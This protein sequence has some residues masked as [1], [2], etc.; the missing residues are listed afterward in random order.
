MC[1]RVPVLVPLLF[2]ILSSAHAQT[3]LPP[4]AAPGI[5]SEPFVLTATVVDKKGRPVDGLKASDFIIT[6]GKVAQPIVSFD[7]VD[8]PVSVGIVFDASDSMLRWTT[9]RKRNT[10]MGALDRFLKAGNDANKYFV[11]TFG[12]QT[13]LILDWNSDRLMIISAL[14]SVAPQGQTVLYDGL[15]SALQKLKDSRN[16]KRVLFLITDGDDSSSHHKVGEVRELL[17]ESNI[18][19][20]SVM[21]IDDEYPTGLGVGGGYVDELTTLSGGEDIFPQVCTTH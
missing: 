1:K 14:A 7:R 8:E 6:E 3:N 15:F 17:R 12:S 13:S 5:R 10:L 2:L 19:F 20:Y 11:Q 16:S 4:Q 9:Q 21:M 18:L